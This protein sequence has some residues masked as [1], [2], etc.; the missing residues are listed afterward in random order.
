M[1]RTPSATTRGAGGECPPR[2]PWRGRERG[3]TPAASRRGGPNP[4]R[5]SATFPRRQSGESLP[6]QRDAAYPRAVTRILDLADRHPTATG[7]PLGWDGIP[8][9][10]GQ[11]SLDH[12]VKL[13]LREWRGD[14]TRIG[15]V[16]QMVRE[17][18]TI[19]AGLLAYSLPPV[20]TGRLLMPSAEA[21]EQEKLKAF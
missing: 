2:R 13:P 6:P 16:D 21:E 14:Y 7:E 19:Q 20:G 3:A 4:P 12:N 18:A 1:P 10:G 9:Y 11:V 15:I 5:G 8:V 17:D